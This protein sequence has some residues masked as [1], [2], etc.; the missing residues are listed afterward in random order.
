MDQAQRYKELAAR[1]E[2]KTLDS[3]YHAAFY[4]LSCEQG[5]FDV[6]KKH[7]N[8]MGIGFE[9]LKRSMRGFD[10]TSLQVVEIAHNLFEWTGKCKVTPFDISRMGYPYMEQVCNAIWIASG[11]VKVQIRDAENGKLEMILDST[12]YQRTQR[13]HSRMEQMYT[14]MLESSEDMGMGMGEQNGGIGIEMFGE[15]DEDMEMER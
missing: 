12:P 15:P 10:E 14:E 1:T 4:L 5:I 8:A 6:A 3:S 9:G 2:G 7:V 13:L 11:E